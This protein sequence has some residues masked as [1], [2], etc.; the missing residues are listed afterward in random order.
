MTRPTAACTT[1]RREFLARSTGTAAGAALASLSI[2]RTAH[3]AGDDQIRIALIGC[4]GRGVGAAVNALGN[5]GHANVKLVALADAFQD[6]V[7]FAKQALTKRFPDKVDVPEERQF[8]GLDCY[9]GAMAAGANVVLLCGP[10]GFRPV[11]FEAAVAAG[12]HVFMEKPVATDAPGVR[13]IM[14]A[15][16]QAKQ[17]RLAVAVGHHL[18]HEVKH[19]EAIARIREG[20]IGQLTLMRAYFNSTGV[21]VRP[22][23]P[24]QTEMQYQTRNWYYFNW[25]SGDHIVEQHV[26]DLDV[27]NWMANALPIEAN[28]MGGRQVRVGK[29]VGEIFDH[30]FVEFTYPGGLRMFS[31]CRHQPG[32]WNSFSEHAHGTKG[33]VNI[34]GHGTAEMILADGERKHWDRGPDGHQIEQDVLFR[35]LAA[36]EP[37]NEA[38]YGATSTMTAILGRMATYSGKIIKWDEALASNLEIVPRNLSWDADPGPKPG[39]DGIYPCAVPG[40]TQVL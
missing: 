11:Q 9:V 8:T 21:W 10:P 39:P 32:C 3:A 15:N 5:A 22:R 29:D 36:G 33:S 38:D 13:R 17:K 2:A 19:Q 26:H 18:R 6:R 28:G 37:H 23:Q 27:C 31:Q 12:K 24:D 34:Q 4:G 1:S 14:A 7:D 30:H 25:L 35:K 16:E 40:V 20:V